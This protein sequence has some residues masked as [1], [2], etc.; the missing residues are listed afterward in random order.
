MYTFPIQIVHEKEVRLKYSMYVMGCKVGPY[1]LGNFLFD[2]TYLVFY[3]TV[4]II[5]GSLLP[6]VPLIK[7]INYKIIIKYMFILIILI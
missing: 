2:L 3:I 4:F 7:V 5:T 6:N 1:W